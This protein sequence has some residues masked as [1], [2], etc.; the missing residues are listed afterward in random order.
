MEPSEAVPG[1]RTAY[2]KAKKRKTTT[3]DE[4]GQPYV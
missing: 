3:P 1:K 4:E 2:P